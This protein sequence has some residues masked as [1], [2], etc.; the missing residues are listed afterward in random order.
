[1]RMDYIIFSGILVVKSQIASRK[2]TPA[3]PLHGD[4]RLR[5][6]FLDV[7]TKLISGGKS[8]PGAGEK[9]DYYYT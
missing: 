8:A 5:G 1:M 7:E 6:V 2:Q 4:G 3:S 9:M